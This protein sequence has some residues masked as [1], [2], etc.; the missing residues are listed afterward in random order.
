MHGR[1][2]TVPRRR[3]EELKLFY[4]I[5]DHWIAAEEEVCCSKHA[6]GTRKKGS[7]RGSGSGLQSADE[8]NKVGS[9]IVKGQP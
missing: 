5:C 9:V 1:T 6:R 4:K 2:S 7:R 8:S 3:A